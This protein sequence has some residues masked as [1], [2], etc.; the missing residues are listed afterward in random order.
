MIKSYKALILIV[1]IINFQNH[2]LVIS[3]FFVFFFLSSFLFDGVLIAA[4]SRSIVLPRIK[5]LLGRE[6]AD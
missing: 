3:F 6:Y 4:F 5:I 1:F 2:F